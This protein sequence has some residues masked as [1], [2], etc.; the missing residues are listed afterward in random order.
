MQKAGRACSA[1][2]LMLYAQAHD[3]LLGRWAL[4]GVVVVWG[5]PGFTRAVGSSPIMLNPSSLPLQNDLESRNQPSIK[6]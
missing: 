4:L 5:L 6:P 2:V 1:A 3:C